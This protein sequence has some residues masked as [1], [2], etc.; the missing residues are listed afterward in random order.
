M[1]G[2]TVDLAG[3]ARALAM[4]GAR[5][6]PAHLGE[7]PAVEAVADPEVRSRLSAWAMATL[8]LVGCESA[9]NVDR[10]QVAAL[11]MVNGGALT[12]PGAFDAPRVGEDSGSE[13]G[14]TRE[15]NARDGEQA[16]PVVSPES[17]AVSS[18]LLMWLD[19]EVRHGRASRAAAAS[20]G[21]AVIE[22]TRLGVERYGSPL[23][24]HNGR[25]AVRDLAEEVVDGVQYATQALMET[26]DVDQVAWL[27][28]ARAKLLGAAADIERV[29]RER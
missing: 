14:G 23:M 5:H 28:A 18:V 24:S 25:D 8:S 11:G 2:L 20:L 21:D 13:S 15:A 26:T 12:G 10:A 3:A 4:A 6:W 16:R 9:V 27:W 7:R 29:R 22:R 1:M 19:D 17:E